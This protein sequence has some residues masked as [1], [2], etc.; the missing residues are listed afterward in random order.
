MRHFVGLF[1]VFAILFTGCATTGTTGGTHGPTDAAHSKSQHPLKQWM[2]EQSRAK[3]KG[4]MGALIGAVAGAGAAA[5]TGR[6]PLAGAAVGAVAG[7][8][9]GFLIGRR[10]D[11]I[12]GSRDEAVR[13]LDYDPSQGYVMQVDEVSFQPA[14]P[15]PGDDVVMTVRYLVVG[16]DPKE[17]LTV[18]STTGVKYDGDYVMGDG[19]GKFKIKHGGGIVE[20]KITLTLPKDAPSGSYALVAVLED[21]QGRCSDDGEQ[22]LYLG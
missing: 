13:K 8:L 17:E 9:A 12:F 5:L 6:N 16:P 3:K 11:K 2:S 4:I 1:L 21:A 22:P 19:P 14:N 15:S 10:Q 20:S 18:E 7:G